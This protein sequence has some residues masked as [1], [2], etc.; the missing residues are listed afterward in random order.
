[1]NLIEEKEKLVELRKQLIVERKT[2]MGKMTE[3][4]ENV[5]EDRRYAFEYLDETIKALSN[6]IM[7]IYHA[8]VFINKIWQEKKTV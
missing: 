8:D 6:V 4:W 5:W 7:C 1:M 2:L 3:E